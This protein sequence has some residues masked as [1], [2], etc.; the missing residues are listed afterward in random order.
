MRARY[1]TGSN[2]VQT[3]I[4]QHAAITV[5]HVWHAKL[6]LAVRPAVEVGLT[7]TA[8]GC[9]IFTTMRDIAA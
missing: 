8:G 6:G 2:R 9:N 5:K 7:L 3:Q 1:R 4:G